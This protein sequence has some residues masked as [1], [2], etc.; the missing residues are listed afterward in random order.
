VRARSAAE[1]P[2]VTP[3]R[4]SIGT[5][6]AVPKRALFCSS[7]TIIGMRSSSRRSPVIG[8]QIRPRP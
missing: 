4:A 3:V 5:Q 6:N 1:I 7:R 8:R 2:V